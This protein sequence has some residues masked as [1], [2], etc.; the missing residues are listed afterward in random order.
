MIDTTEWIRRP[1][2]TGDNRCWPCTVTNGVLL[3]IGVGVLTIAGRRTVAAA[4]AV[5]G[6]VAIWLRGYLV[7]YTPRFAPRLVTAL[8]FGFVD[9][10]DHTGRDAGSLSDT[11]I[12]T[13]E[14]AETDVPTGEAVVTA[15][16]EV[17]VVVPAGEELALD[18]SFRDEWHRK[19]ARLRD[20]GF[21]GLAAEANDLTDPS[22]DVRVGRDWRGR[23]SAIRLEGDGGRS[24]SFGEAV[25]VAELAAARALESRIDDEAIRLAAGRPLRSLLDRCP[26]CDGD[27]TVSRSTCCGEVTPIGSTPAERLICPDCDVRLFT[28]D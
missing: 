6:I 26:R 3:T 8:P 11:G 28:Y 15:L 25:A 24:V 5:I 16:L 4:V 22:I 9:H 10:G 21:A 7:P 12:A 2:Y 17:G 27:L 14:T 23:D 19:M 13:D 1:E 20:L 18:E